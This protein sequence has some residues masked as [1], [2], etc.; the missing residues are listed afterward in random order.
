[1]KEAPKR[2]TTPKS[3]QQIQE[4]S[5]DDLLEEVNEGLLRLERTGGYFEDPPE[6]ETRSRKAPA[7]R[8]SY[9]GNAFDRTFGLVPQGH[10]VR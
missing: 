1:M 6:N 3:N 8:E 5:V 4:H 7:R 2:T 10:I 9:V